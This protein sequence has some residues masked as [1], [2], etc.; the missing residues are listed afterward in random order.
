MTR[1]T[2]HL[3]QAV[4]AGALV[5]L[6]GCANGV[7]T[8]ADFQD[9]P[10]K[11]GLS[12]SDS[13]PVA[14]K[15]SEI[16]SLMVSSCVYGVRRLGDETTV[17]NRL[18]LLRHDLEDALGEKARDATVNVLRYTLYWSPNIGVQARWKHGEPQGLYGGQPGLL[19][20]MTLGQDCREDQVGE[21]WAEPTREMIDK[22]PLVVIG[23][24]SMRGKTYSVR[25]VHVPVQNFS[26][27]EPSPEI[28]T[29]LRKANAELARKMATD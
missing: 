17:P 7:S 14:D 13:R 15:K 18:V 29:A 8:L 9:T 24:L 25:S 6:G 11:V 26:I 21:S 12:L 10:T 20:K 2:M 1:Q 16:L 3:F 4:S 23:E 22:A 27:T 19:D 28:L 5:F